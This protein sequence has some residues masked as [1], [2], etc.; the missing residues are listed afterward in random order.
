MNNQVIC[1]RDIHMNNHIIYSENISDNIITT[2][3]VILLLDVR[4]PTL[5]VRPQ[6]KSKQPPA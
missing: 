4:Y 3:D 5:R 1:C 2:Y 6:L